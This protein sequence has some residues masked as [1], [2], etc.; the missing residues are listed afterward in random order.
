[1]SGA[2]QG[3]VTFLPA[4][5]P[6]R[7]RL[8]WWSPDGGAPP[9]DTGATTTLT[10]ARA[11]GTTVRR[12]PV[13]AAVLGVEEGLAALLADPAPGASAA[14]W[15]AAARL[16][17]D[18]VAR[19]R[20]LPGLTEA[21][22][23]AWR[24]GPLDATDLLR[25]RDLAAALPP[26]GHPVA[27][28]GRSPL[29]VPAPE[30]LLRA[31]LDAVADT[32][33]RT[34]AAADAL[35]AP[36]AATAPQRLPGARGWAALAAAGQDAGV[37]LSLRLDLS[38]Y[39]LF[40]PEG[41]EGR[42]GAGAA[43]LQVHSLADPTRIAD[44]AALWSGERLPGFGPR[45]RIDAA[46]ALR[47]AARVWAPLERL[48]DQPVPDVLSLD[49]AELSDLL[50][51]A[52]ERLRA[53]GVPVHWPRELARELTAEA[54]VRGA[55]GSATDGTPFFDADRLLEFRWQVALGGERL[56]RKSVV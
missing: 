48:A 15:Q 32:L 18:L 21:D 25:L 23:D 20:L 17:L 24:A 22:E 4:V 26:E 41:E 13:E 44:A 6:R 11:R 52:A 2:G 51:V 8:A 10:V 1:M 9:R 49:D 31:F 56:D 5:L 33:P 14:C 30:A 46:L 37:S 40:D 45:A 19:G 16:A 39:G 50:G 34:P 29:L 35:G 55:P 28:E 42:R 54:E 38:A 12:V 3:A 47:R 43:V 27:L 53:A 7:G 36:F